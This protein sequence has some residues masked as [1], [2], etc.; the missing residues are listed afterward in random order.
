[1]NTLTGAAIG[2][3]IGASDIKVGNLSKNQ[4]IAILALA[5][6]VLANLHKEATSNP[7]DRPTTAMEAYKFKDDKRA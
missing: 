3:L 1:M 2:G 6:A 7:I 5:G 4:K